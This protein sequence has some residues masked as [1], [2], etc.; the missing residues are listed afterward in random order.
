MEVTV[1]VGPT[2]GVEVDVT[3]VVVS[4]PGQVVIET[5]GGF[6]GVHNDI[7]GRSTAG[8]HPAS[9]ISVAATPANY[10]PSDPDVESHLVAIDAAITGGGGAV[11]SVN[12]ET[13][14]VVLDA[15]DVG[16]DPAGTAAAAVSSHTSA[17]DPHGDRAYTDSGIAAL[18]SV[19]QPLDSDLTSIAALSTTAFGRALLEL[20]DAA[21]LR[22]AAGL[23][24][25]A[26]RN[27]GTTAGTVAAGDDS[28]LSDQRTP[29]DNSVTSA[30]IANGTIVDE[31]I[32][33]SAA[34]ALSKLA[35]DP[36]DRANHTGTQ[37]ATTITVSDV[38][39]IVTQQDLDD[40]WALRRFNA[41]SPVAKISGC[42]YPCYSYALHP[43]STNGGSCWWHTGTGGI[44]IG[45]GGIVF[46]P[47]GPFPW[48]LSFAQI[49]W[50]QP[51]ASS[52]GKLIRFGLYAASA[53]TGLPTGSPTT[54][55]TAS[56]A[57]TGERTATFSS[58]T[59]PRGAF[60]WLA[61]Q[62]EESNSATLY[63]YAISPAGWKASVAFP[64][65]GLNR[66]VLCVTGTWVD[67]FPASPSFSLSNIVSGVSNAYTPLVWFVAL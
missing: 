13:G 49:K 51:N 41:V 66:S 11:T 35:V 5:G 36:L 20:A 23:G 61:I 62:M 47:V 53:S 67:G 6:A 50:H 27:V 29:L 52:A 48:E 30:K 39:G 57:S 14:A 60:R 17:S 8:A 45:S 56:A 32:S 54:L 18:S 2:V 4:V 31:D 9:S 16:A 55:G 65:G 59:I 1:E 43:S 58:T 10:S 44:G 46:V 40:E 33:A 21:A 63:G 3:E 24:D 26:T 12:G 7:G 15:T 34:I 25:A 38:D 22:I 19:Y 28:R 64:F 42:A 37:A